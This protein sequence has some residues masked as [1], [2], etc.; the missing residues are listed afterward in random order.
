MILF[1]LARFGFDFFLFTLT[2]TLMPRCSN[3]STLYDGSQTRT[4][5][6][7]LYLLKSFKNFNC[8][9]RNLLF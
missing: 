1:K 5:T 2:I 7:A 8:F 6:P 9:K 4:T 3:L